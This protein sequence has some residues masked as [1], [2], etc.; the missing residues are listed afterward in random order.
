MP[1]CKY[2]NE[3]VF[4]EYEKKRG[5]RDVLRKPLW[6]KF[7]RM[8]GIK[9]IRGSKDPSIRAIKV[10]LTAKRTPTPSHRV[11]GTA[12]AVRVEPHPVVAEDEVRRARE[13]ATR[14]P[15]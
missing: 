12:N 2:I 9:K 1:D 5:R 3:N 13:P 8:Q 4:C 15:D 11:A 10:S 6:K 14:P 7:A